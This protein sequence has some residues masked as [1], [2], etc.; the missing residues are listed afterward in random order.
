MQ[1]VLVACIHAYTYSHDIFLKNKLAKRCLQAFLEN[2][3]ISQ[4]L[5]PIWP[6]FLKLVVYTNFVNGPTKLAKQ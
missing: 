4:H 1:L 3:R 2:L 6:C 5:G